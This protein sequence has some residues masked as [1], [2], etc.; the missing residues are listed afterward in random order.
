MTQKRF[1]DPYDTL[2]PEDRIRTTI[3]IAGNRNAFFKSLHN[4]K[5]T[6]QTT[7]NILLEKLYDELQRI[8]LRSYDP[9]AYERTIADC[10]IRC[11]VADGGT[12]QA[13]AGNDTIGNRGLA[14]AATGRP[15]L[16]SD[17]T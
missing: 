5:G 17:L 14:P 9:D 16:P 2:P 7:I 13:V 11:A 1:I 15:S 3:D 10:C 8:G 6:L 12:N 4:R